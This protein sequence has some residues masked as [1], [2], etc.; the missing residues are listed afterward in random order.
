MISQPRPKF[1]WLTERKVILGL[2]TIASMVF[3][4]YSSSLALGF[5]GDDWI[6]LD[7]AGRL[8]LRD[9]L[10]RY[11]NPSAQTAWYRPVQGVLF[12]IE[13]H[14][15]QVDPLG[16]H[17]LNVFLH[18]FNC[19]LILALVYR[20][21]ANRRSGF[22]AA[23]IFATLPTAALSVFWPGV[24]DTLETF[25]Y[26]STVWFWIGY[27]QHRQSR[28]FWLAFGAF[29]FA[30]FTK[31][32]GVTLPA[33]L[34]LIDWFL[35]RKKVSRLDSVRRYLW[36]V[37]AWIAYFP[38]EYIVTRRSVFVSQEGYTPS[39][40]L[41]SNLLDYLSTL[42]FPW[43]FAPPLS[44]IWLAGVAAFLTFLILARKQYR[45][46]PIVVSAVLVVLPIAP[47]P[48][49]SNRFLYLPLVASAIFFAV[50][51]D[52]VWQRL[53]QVRVYHALLV[54]A[55]AILVAGSTASIWDAAAS[56]GEF[57]R[58]SRVTFRN[59][60]QAH[61]TFPNDTML[62]FIDPP[63]PGPNLSGMF[64]SR[65]GSSV[66]V[67]ANDSDQPARLRDHAT[68]FVYYFNAKGDPIEQHVD[69]N[70]SVDVTPTLPVDFATSIR[71]E[72]VE[73]VNPAVTEGEPL[74]LLLYWRALNR[75]NGDYT[76]FVHLVDQ[77]GTEVAGYE[78]YPR[79]GKSPTSTWMPGQRIVDAII[80]P[81]PNTL[82]ANNY[83]RLEVGMFDTANRLRL[84]ISRTNDPAV[85]DRISLGP[86]S[87][88][89]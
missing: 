55:V 32:I 68:A 57:A 24:I 46:I 2:L 72:G 80:L 35:I 34:C 42:T 33:T 88:V 1:Y 47:F 23:I 86:L 75:V 61:P 6:F 19:L 10:V 63:V 14:I 71:L 30:L 62:Y 58:V 17:L 49:V 31:E 36:F 40:R 41:L 21:T 12:L 16:Y 70:A 77:N 27:L 59:I 5:Y 56:F 38:V 53:P 26:L 82:A 51:F 4:A 8:S 79:G 81:T 76:V 50:L 45:V 54:F 84:A 48:N 7:L 15:F 74:L 25:F 22:I 83:Y 64:F 78:K 60:R 87:I 65:Y 28:D 11:F 39:L 44:Y 67:G 85:V 89:K 20:V 69:K 9:Y 18:L 73:L 66:F 13:Y 52:G 37:A 3:V 43:F 29:L